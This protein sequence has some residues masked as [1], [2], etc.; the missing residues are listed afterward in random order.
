MGIK[1]NNFLKSEWWKG[2]REKKLKK[3]KQCY[4]CGNKL[5]LQVHHYNYRFKYSGSASK[6]VKDTHL[7]CSG[8]HQEFHRLYGVKGNM[9]KEMR[10][11]TKNVRIQING[12]KKMYRELMEKEDFIKN[13]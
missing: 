2:L 1:Y 12:A 3:K 13:I 8:C 10:E 11:F 5:Y 6:A 4:V 7:L 9:E